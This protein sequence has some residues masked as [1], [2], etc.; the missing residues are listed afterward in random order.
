[1][2]CILGLL[3]VL[4]GVRGQEEDCSDGTWKC[5]TGC[6]DTANKVCSNLTE[7]QCM[8][9]SS[10]WSARCNCRCS[11]K[12]CDMGCWDEEDEACHDGLSEMQCA[13]IYGHVEWSKTCNCR[14]DDGKIDTKVAEP[15]TGQVVIWFSPVTFVVLLR[16]SLEVMIMLV[17]MLQFLNKTK[18]EGLLDASTFTRLRREVLLGASLGFVIVLVLG[19]VLLIFMA[20]VKKAISSYWLD[21]L[22]LIGAAILLTY[23]S[24][25]F[26]K[27]VHT[28][29]SH[30]RKMKQ[31][32]DATLQSSRDAEVMGKAAFG[33]KHAFLVFSAV[34]GFRE[35][36]ETIIFL[37]A[38]VPDLDHPE[39]KL[40]VSIIT[41]LI[42]SRLLGCMLMYSTSKA[43]LNLFIKIISTVLLFLAAGF[44][45]MSMHA[46]QELAAFGTWSPRAE[47]PWQNQAI[48]DASGCC[49]DKT[50]YFFVMMRA[51]L[52]YQD[53]PTPIEVFAWILYWIVALAAGYF[54]I[55][56][57]KQQM[58]A[59]LE[60]WRRE[61]EEAAL[62]AQ[63]EDVNQT[64]PEK[65]GNEPATAGTVDL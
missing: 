9:S 54:M 32:L 26:Y 62:K 33:K 64:E 51:L 56:R 22:I 59:M 7:A 30:T 36:L 50:N 1:M 25:N 10:E 57:A 31:R 6:F 34:T 53:Q 44:F 60:R 49:S 35:G 29:E 52:G 48:F 45:S 13:E 2:R 65:I 63:E 47:R 3:L 38:V 12:I 39:L 28:M 43:P 37:F 17:V 5:D 21:G 41:A 14:D 27:M 15:R 46:F 42:V 11:R 61:D 16:E 19:V 55:R 24:L 23:L 4:S 58:S 40:P 20:Q 8:G 18:A